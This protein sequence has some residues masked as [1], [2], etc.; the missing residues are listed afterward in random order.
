M[1]VAD[2]VLKMLDYEPIYNKKNP[3]EWMEM[4]ALE[5]KANFFETR[6]SEYVKA[7]HAPQ[8]KTSGDSAQDLLCLDESVDF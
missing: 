6:V 8:N 7:T 2:R 3:F 1:F 4:S 5:G